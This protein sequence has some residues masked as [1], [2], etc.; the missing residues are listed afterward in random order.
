MATSTIRDNIMPTGYTAEVQKGISFEKYAL[1]CAK[2]FGALI[3]MRDEPSD[4]EI[5]E[6]L[7]PSDH[8][9][10]KKTSAED[11]LKSLILLT[12]DAANKKA[13]D[14]FNADE[15]YRV[16]KLKE[17][18]V[19]EAR[20]NEMLVKA[21]AWVSPSKD[22]DELK[23]FMISQIEKSIKFDC[24]GDYYEKPTTK[25]TG[26]QWRSEKMEQ[27]HKDIAYHIKHYREEIERTND[28]NKWINSLRNSLA[29]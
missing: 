11:E 12:D 15:L 18:S 3:T 28:R 19:I 29:I 20:Y 1:G 26:E 2:A 5:P 21:K 7:E 9:F 16:N 4:K 22:H 25:M 17:E 8:H 27:L 23:D 10:K 13:L 24:G 14:K 6:K